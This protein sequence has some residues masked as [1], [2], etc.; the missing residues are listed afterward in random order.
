MPEANPKNLIVGFDVGSTTVKSVVVDTTTDQ[1]IW[2]DYQRHDTKQPE[3]CLEFLKRMEEEAGIKAGESRVFVTGSGGGPVGSHIGAKF[4]QEVNAVSLAVEK[5]YPECG[6]VVELGGQDAKIIIF[7]EDP[8]TGR[9]KKIPSMNDKCAGGTGAVIDKINAKL[10]IPAE[11]LCN[12][13]YL[14][15]SSTP[16][17]GNAASSRRRMSTGYRRAACRRRS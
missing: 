11:E 17:L 7:K 1:I 4:V 10:R 6:S 12:M 16:W 14:G 9:K 15:Q 13:G 3:K 2:S 5:L 8:E